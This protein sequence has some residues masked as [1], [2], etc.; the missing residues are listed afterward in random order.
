MKHAG[1]IARSAK[2]IVI[3]LCIA[4]T[5]IACG[6]PKVRI[7]GNAMSPALN[8]GEWWPIVRTVDPLGC[9]DL[10]PFYYPRDQS[11][12]FI[13]RAIALPGERGR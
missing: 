5:V 8:D 3:V 6:G 2:W 1:G 13:K 11:K 4:P 10:V 12:S 9:G 7:G